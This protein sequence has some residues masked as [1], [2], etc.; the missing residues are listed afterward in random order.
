MKYFKNPD[1]ISF[2][3]GLKNK[4]LTSNPGLFQISDLGNPKREE[5]QIT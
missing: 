1:F 2:K 3:F 5:E 4:S